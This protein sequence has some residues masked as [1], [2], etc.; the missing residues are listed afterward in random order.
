[1]ID[2]EFPPIQQNLGKNKNLSWKSFNDFPLFVEESSQFPK[3][4]KLGNCY[5]IAPLVSIYAAKPQQIKSLFE[6]HNNNYTT[7]RFCI[8]GEWQKIT[9]DHHFPFND[10]KQKVVY[11]KLV[12]GAIWAMILEKAWAILYGSYKQISAGF[13]SINRSSYKQVSNKGSKFQ[14]NFII[15]RYIMFSSWCKYSKIKYLEQ[16]MLIHCSQSLGIK[17]GDQHILTLD[18]FKKRF[19]S[20][21]CCYHFDGY[22]YKRFQNN[23]DLGVLFI[24]KMKIEFNQVYECEKVKSDILEPVYFEIQIKVPGNYFFQNKVK[25]KD[26]FVINEI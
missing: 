9:V 15:D 1:M 25:I 12:D 14:G 19:V 20:I 16:T 5:W 4:G 3:Q 23:Y 6:S 21:E 26:G 11:C 17:E 22:Q 24:Q 13:N 7:I 18:E 10:E 8:D 2:Q